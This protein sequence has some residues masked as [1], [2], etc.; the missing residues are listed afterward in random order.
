MKRLILALMILA[1]LFI[2]TS[3]QSQEVLVP[4]R[5]EYVLVE[6][7]V[8]VPTYHYHVVAPSVVYRSVPVVTRYWLA[9]SGVVYRVSPPIVT[10]RTVPPTYF[11]PVYGEP[12]RTF[13]FG[14]RYVPVW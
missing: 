4:L 6:P 12:V 14:R 9:P 2:C 7:S 3:A 8:S 13:L 1:T 10:Y 5:T 11:T